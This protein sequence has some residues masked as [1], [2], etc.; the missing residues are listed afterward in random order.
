[1]LIERSNE[2]MLQDAVIKVCGVGG[3]GGNAVNRMIESGM[4]NVDFIAIN[5][6]V[7]DLRH[8]LATTR[9]QIGQGKG[10][11]AGARPEV[12][13]QACEEDRESVRNVIQGAEMVFLTAGLG[14][15]T[16]TGASPIVAE[17]ATASGA[18]VVAVVTLP[19]SYEGKERMDNALAGVEELE[20]HVDS[21]IIVPNDRLAQLSDDETRL[22]DAFRKGDEVLHNG[23]RA[24]S[25]LITVPGLINVDFADVRTLMKSR[26]RAR[27]D[28]CVRGQ[29]RAVRAAKD[30]INCPLLE[31]SDIHGA[32]GVIINIRG[33]N[34]MRM[35]EVM[36]A[37]EYIK[38]NIGR[39]ATIIGGA[40]VDEE[41]RPEIQITVIAAGFEKKDPSEYSVCFTPAVATPRESKPAP[42]PARETVTKTEEH[43]P[44]EK[45]LTAKPPVEVPR[46]VNAENEGTTRSEMEPTPTGTPAPSFS[47]SSRPNSKM[48]P[49]L[50][51]VL[52]KKRQAYENTLSK[53]PSPRRPT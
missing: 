53:A 25:E 31:Q 36:K 23:V 42:A 29:D 46:P 11:G 22:V 51:K 32:K 33:G 18:L 1:M 19:F 9:L 50:Q 41:E 34:D 3:A 44:V 43:Q 15:G 7:M 14:G 12:G 52:D 35:Q 37:N 20:K 27:W 38:A 2:N 40:V 47:S 17:E 45:K 5:T 16:G 39:E 4:T 24:I 26:G 30:A 13:R 8:S 28:R 48:P 10:V 49:Y 6:D 21:M